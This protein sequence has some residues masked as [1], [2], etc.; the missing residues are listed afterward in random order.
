MKT[1]N[2][3][4][5]LLSILFLLEILLQIHNP[6]EFTNNHNELIIHTNRTLIFENP[7]LE[8]LDPIV[9]NKLNSIGCRGEEPPENFE[10]YLTIMAVGSSTTVCRTLDEGKDWIHQFAQKAKREINQPFW[11]NNAG[12][13]GNSTFGHLHYLRNHLSK[14]KPDFVFYLVGISE[15]ERLDLNHHDLAY[16]KNKTL[17]AR[18]W[19]KKNSELA[20]LLNGL[21][22]SYHASKIQME[23]SVLD[24]RNAEYLETNSILLNEKLKAQKPF[25]IQYEK[26]LRTLILETKAADIQPIVLTHPLLFGNVID[27]ES[28]IN[29]RNVKVKGYDNGETYWQVLESYNECTRKVAKE[30]NI[31]LID[32]A[33]AMPKEMKYFTDAMHFTN[34]GAEKFGE[35]LWDSLKVKRSEF[36]SM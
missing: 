3:L 28:G 7:P 16:Q 1:R 4:L 24:L 13:D 17:S 8:G 5:E 29:L 2:F 36:L 19:L 25:L 11:V 31:T 33:H 18:D 35:I 34:F 12:L 20:I 15:I 14:I 26:R 32:M 9:K 6:R 22:R 30:E 27:L 23:Y 10:D 21:Y